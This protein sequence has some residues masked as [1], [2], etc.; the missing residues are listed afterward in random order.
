MSESTKK[1]TKCEA[2]IPADN[3][4]SLCPR[5]L[6]QAGFETQPE[7]PTDG[8]GSNSYQP[9]FI[10]PTPA[11][12]SS[13]FPQLEI[14]EVIGHGGMGVVYKARQIELDRIVA[15]KILRPGISQEP[16]FAERFQ[17]EA[18]ALAKLNHP[19]II[20]VY[21]FGRRDS[22]FYFIMEYVD[23]TNLRHLTRVG[24]IEPTE[25][26]QIVPQVCSAL[27]YAHDHGVVHRDIKPENILI[28]KE[29][30]VRIADFGLAKLAGVVEA[31]P[32]TGTWQVMGTPHYMAPEQFEKPTTVDHRADI[33]S[34]G[35]VIY[36]LLTGELPIGRFP[37][38]S[39][40]VRV[41][42]RMDE[43]VL[44]SLDKEP[45]RRYQ[46]VTDV[47]TA[48]AEASGPSDPSR[49]DHAKQ[50]IRKN[51][52]E[53]QQKAKSWRENSRPWKQVPHRIADWLFEHKQRLAIGLMWCG[54]LDVLLSLMTLAQ[55]P[56]PTNND[57]EFFAFMSIVAGSI[58]LFLGRQMRKGVVTGKLLLVAAFCLVPWFNFF[59][60]LAIVRP[61]LV[62]VA[63]FVCL[64]PSR[65]GTS[66]KEGAT[67][68]TQWKQSFRSLWPLMTFRIVMFSVV[69]V[70]G[71]G[72]AC[73]ATFR[74]VSE[75]WYWRV[76][77]AEYVIRDESAHVVKPASLA[78]QQLHIDAS[79][80]GESSGMRLP[81]ALLQRQLLQLTIENNGRE[82]PALEI[83][84]RE[85][86]CHTI[87]N[88]KVS[89]ERLPL[90]ESTLRDWMGASGVE[91]SLPQV[92]AE[93][94]A[95]YQFV[96]LMRR[97]GGTC[98]RLSIGQV[99]SLPALENG[100]R[101]VLR[102][103]YLMRNDL[104]P[105]GL[106]LE[107]DLFEV[108][109]A[110]S[111]P[112][113]IVRPKS[114]AEIIYFGTLLVVFLTGLLRVLRILYVSLWRPA[115]RG[116]EDCDNSAVN[117][118]VR[119]LAL[120]AS[121]TLCCLLVLMLHNEV[122]KAAWQSHWLVP[123]NLADLS[124]TVIGRVV[125]GYL[126]V[127]FV[128]ACCGFLARPVF[129]SA[130]WWIGTLGGSLAVLAAPLNL[131]TFPTGLSAWIALT[132]VAVADTFRPR[133]RGSATVESTA[134]K[135]ASPADAPSVSPN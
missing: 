10:P 106:L 74:A 121:G 83:H 11:E 52:A 8:A 80:S 73:A 61:L 98:H 14:I 12:L 9:T 41:D 37:L 69:G 66:G 110:A 99:R 47:A 75:M 40:K 23:G 60:L 111:V 124:V 85:N 116:P 120:A 104:I 127:A 2:E 42:V 79:V 45:D 1:C 108:P 48:V 89:A 24:S 18:R 112:R 123:D 44:R 96:E 109:R 54:S 5:C 38:P 101:Q 125:M 102:D 119:S 53:L 26:L 6:L 49:V 13:Q 72:A 78:Y 27:Q 82:T 28:S 90:Q 129:R 94:D 25:A 107:S 17:R 77:P 3:S 57:R 68:A 36:E 7:S 67:F 134:T 87:Q 100:I 65:D 86:F 133:K 63:I 113:P 130:G 88:G 21:D 126:A 70:A 4:A 50:W 43:V 16:G 135:A 95:L 115:V 76:V 32:L 39:D 35:V 51:A 131:L 132:D 97:T 122:M 128:I 64:S 103:D 46:H 55:L 117:W 59:A 62:A 34:L 29:G 71:W 20:T 22:L 114:W 33:Y 56:G 15:L 93:L 31:A 91:V 84:L 58:T 30:D 92:K 81:D 19:H 118:S 105:V